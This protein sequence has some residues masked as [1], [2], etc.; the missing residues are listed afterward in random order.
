MAAIARQVV[1]GDDESGTPGNGHDDFK[2][3]QWVCH[4]FAVQ[5]IVHGDGLAMEQRIRV[6]L[7]VAA[8]GHRDTRHGGD[9][10]A[11]AVCILLG[12]HGVAGILAH[13][14]VRQV[15]LR[16]G[17]SKALAVA[18]QLH[19]RREG[20][21]V[22]VRVRRRQAPGYHAEDCATQPELNGG[23]SAPGHGYG[24]GTAKVH[25]LGKA[26]LQPQV[27][28]HHRWHEGSGLVE[29]RAVYRQAVDVLQ[30]KPGVNQCHASQ[31]R[32]LLKV[33]HLWRGCVSFRSIL[34]TAHNRRLACQAHSRLPCRCI[35][36]LI[37]AGMMG[38]IRSPPK[39]RERS[40]AAKGAG[41][42]A[43]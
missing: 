37:L 17:R 14:S 38:Q 42:L 5:Y 22:G 18:A 32:H 4:H 30:R 41:G 24:T 39:P 3:M 1:G 8:L 11:V 27:L 34:G 19:C 2:N 31:V 26:K 10:V 43:Q 21:R 36:R 20:G 40:G 9:V 33:K 6:G 15:E 23:G 25:S 12:D 13:V 35:S 29:V 28:C 7:R 16:L